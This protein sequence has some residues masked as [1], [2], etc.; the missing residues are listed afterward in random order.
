V[1]ISPRAARRIASVVDEILILNIGCI[2]ADCYLP[3]AVIAR[4]S[5][6][7]ESLSLFQ[8]AFATG[9]AARKKE[10]GKWALLR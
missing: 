2:A 6:R 1:Y 5:V 3:P 9:Y 7:S 10:K 4:A 8:D